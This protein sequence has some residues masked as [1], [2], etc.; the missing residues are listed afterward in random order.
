MTKCLVE[1]HRQVAELIDLYQPKVCAVESVIF[2]QNSRE[3]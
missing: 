3:P 2:V 1:I